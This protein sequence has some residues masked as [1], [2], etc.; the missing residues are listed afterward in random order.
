MFDPKQVLE[1]LYKD[2]CDEVSRTVLLA[3]NNSETWMLPSA[4]L[5]LMET[6]L[7]RHFDDALDTNTANFALQAHKYVLGS[8]RDFWLKNRSRETCFSCLRNKPYIELPCGHSIC[9]N[10]MTVFGEQSQEDRWVYKMRHCILCKLPAPNTK[11][12]V[13]P[14]TAG[15]SVL[16]IDGGGIRGVLPLTF[17]KLLE[18]RIGLPMPVLNHF[19]VVFGTSSGKL[20]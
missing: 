6:E 20:L 19:K 14:P 7:Q 3:H 9:E 18:H 17:L 8:V 11:V 1:R 4:L 10:C 16:C 15:A 12:R 5:N 2:I 13:H